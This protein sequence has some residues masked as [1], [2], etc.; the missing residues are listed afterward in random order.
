MYSP[1]QDDRLSGGETR[2]L[3][4]EADHQPHHEESDEQEILYRQSSNRDSTKPQYSPGL[5]VLIAPALLAGYE[6]SHVLCPSHANT[7]GIESLSKHSI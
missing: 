7:H 3:T 2:V 1:H 6:V 5:L 4:P